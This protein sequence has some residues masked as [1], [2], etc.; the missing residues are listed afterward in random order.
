MVVGL[1][2]LNRRLTR[3]IPDGVRRAARAALEENAAVIVAEMKRL[4]PIDQG[5][6]R[7]SIGRR[8]GDAPEGSRA[9]G[10]AR[11]GSETITIYAGGDDA[12]YAIFQEFGTA[13]MPPT[14]FFF[15]AYRSKK[16]GAK[17]R[18]TRRIRK[19]IRDS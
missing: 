6:L 2:R 16:R 9:I 4:V 1:R 8:W 3:T 19:A 7:D 17:S 12:F 15:P 11:T 10:A 14:P 18:V 13:D 5:E